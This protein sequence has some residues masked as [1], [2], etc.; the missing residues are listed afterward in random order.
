MLWPESN[1]RPS[2]GGRCGKK[3]LQFPVKLDVRRTSAGFLPGRPENPACL[4]RLLSRA[5]DIHP[6]PGPPCP[7][8]N[9]DFRRKDYS[10]KCVDCTRWFRRT[11]LNMTKSE[12]NAWFKGQWH[13]GCTPRAP[14]TATPTATS[15]V[16]KNN[17]AP[18]CNSTST[19][20]RGRARSSTNS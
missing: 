7:I 15:T 16:T 2:L 18:S 14:P 17:A 4:R 5:G 9:N 19:A 8:C 11:C 1:P 3:L 12:I 13:C 10:P 6:N 20:G